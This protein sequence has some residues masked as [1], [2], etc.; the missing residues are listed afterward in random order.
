LAE[1]W[2]TTG[3]GGVGGAQREDRRRA[4]RHGHR[5]HDTRPEGKAQSVQALLKRSDLSGIRA[6]HA[7]SLIGGNR[8]CQPGWSL[9]ARRKGLAVELPHSIHCGIRRS[10]A[11][12]RGP[13]CE[14]LRRIALR[15]LHSSGRFTSKVPRRRDFPG[16][17]SRTGGGNGPP[18]STQR[19]FAIMH[20]ESQPTGFPHPAL[21]N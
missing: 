3:R 6:V 18:P 19:G 11:I 10:R 12:A 9:L 17:S 8:G 15:S 4:R 1:P 13:L 2:R 21:D 14:G 7:R 16:S 20:C 5:V